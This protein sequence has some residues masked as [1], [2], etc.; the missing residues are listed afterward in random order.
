MKLHKDLSEFVELLNSNNVRYLVVGAH[1]MAFHGRPRYTSDFDLFV[2]HSADNAQ[3]IVRV[4]EQ[5]GMGSLGVTAEAMAA[6]DVVLQLGVSPNRI[7]LLTTLTGLDFEGVWQKR[8]DAA[9][10]GLPMHFIG[11][12]DLIT[13]K[14][15]LARPQ[16]IADV[17]EL[18]YL[19]SLD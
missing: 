17:H 19:D 10:D 2:S 6:P 13:N 18:N 3:R 4:I 11:K 12:D 14:R 16:D 8:I 7:D 5:F 15:A 1:A 9:I